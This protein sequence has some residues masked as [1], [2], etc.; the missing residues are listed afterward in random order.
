[1][2]YYLHLVVAFP[3]EIL[4][5]ILSRLPVKSLLQ[6]RCVSKS[7]LRLISSTNF[8]KLHLIQSIKNNPKI[9][10][11]TY[12]DTYSIDYETSCYEPKE[13]D[14]PLNDQKLIGSC[15]GIVCLSDKEFYMALWN[16]AT[17]EY[18][19]IPFTSVEDDLMDNEREVVVGFGYDLVAQ[20][21]KVVKS[22]FFYLDDEHREFEQ[23]EVKICTV[24]TKEWRRIDDPPCCLTNRHMVP[25]VNGALHW[26]GG[27]PIAKIIAFDV[28]K[29]DFRFVPWI[30]SVDDSN[31]DVTLGVLRDC[32]STI[33][34]HGGQSEK[35]LDIWLMKEYGVK[36]SWTRL[37]SVQMPVTGI[38]FCSIEPLVLR[39]NDEL[40][41]K[42]WGELYSYDTRNDKV[43]VYCIC[44]IDPYSC[45]AAH[46][47]VE[48]LVAIAPLVCT[49]E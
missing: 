9:I 13:Y 21:Y 14:F 17:K 46:T 39:D 7:W 36:E 29:E 42:S 43:T 16:P 25:Q 11:P 38:E 41:L 18:I 4:I 26:L 2:R 20:K 23:C 12:E 19:E 10:I 47:H 28:G 48:S 37:F 34:Y 40:L 24:G 6:F 44:D 5:E 30:G 1:M 15:N 27:L 45:Y 3:D 31:C 22:V 8:V 35:P 32:L 49:E 33:C